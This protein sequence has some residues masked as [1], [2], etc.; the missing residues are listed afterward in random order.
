MIVL[1]ELGARSS[2]RDWIRPLSKS[3]KIIFLAVSG[4]VVLLIFIAA[5][6]VVFVDANAYKSHLEA[7]VSGALGMEVRIDGRLGIGFFPGILFRLQDVHILN[8]GADIVSAKEA[9]LGVDLLPLLRKKVQIKN[10]ALKQPT[11]SIE[12][13]NDGRFNFE[14]PEAA[15]A[16]SPTLYLAKLSLSDATFLYANKQSGEAL[17]AMDCSLDLHRL[18]LSRGGNPDVMKNLSFTTALACG[19]IR[20]K[21][22]T[23]SDLKVAADGMDGI[24]DFKPVTMHVF[25]AQGSGSIRANFSG[26]T[27]LYHVRYS[28][29]QFLIEDFFKILSPQQVAEGPMDFTANLSMQGKTL[30][31]MKQTLE[32]QISLQGKNLTLIGTDL[33]QAFSRFESSQNFNLVDVGALF[34]V[35]PIGLV[36]T[37]GYDFAS[38]FQGSGRG[39]SIHEL[40]SD[41]KVEHGQAQAQDV[42]MATDE[43][44]FAFKGR[45]DFVNE[46]FDD[47]TVAV[48]DAKGCAK[49]QQSMRGTFSKPV[50]EKPN[51]LQSVT[52]ST[53]EL[54]QKGKELFTDR[55][56]DV[57]YAG[58]VVAPK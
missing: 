37:K 2:P 6:L 29:P 47:V 5:A 3:F 33:D 24:F 31:E 49:A 22:F 58:S 52:G 16:S 56:C 54:L 42:A 20:S 12:R 19:E 34:F 32:G 7:T 57:F 40:V 30:K 43:N 10:I 23:M 15:G 25:G 38:I 48:V 26:T 36:V 51:I 39:S 13:D 11:I 4:F 50:V 8:R 18:H 28:L 17:E 46:R 35:G 44:R 45:L 9:R 27:P 21:A 14:K 55:E 1:F 41:W 53:V